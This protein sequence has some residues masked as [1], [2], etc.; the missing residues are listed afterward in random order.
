MVFLLS[1]FLVI[2]VLAKRLAGKSISDVTYI[3]SS[4]TL[5]LNSINQSWLHDTD[6][7]KTFGPELLSKVL[8]FNMHKSWSFD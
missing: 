7:H 5:N 1:L 3:V 4:E 6:S 8:M 2:S